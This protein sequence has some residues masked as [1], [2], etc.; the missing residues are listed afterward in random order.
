FQALD[1]LGPLAGVGVPV[2]WVERAARQQDFYAFVGIHQAGRHALGGA[3]D[4]NLDD[5]FHGVRFVLA[6]TALVPGARVG[7]F[8][9]D[10][11]GFG[12][13]AVQLIELV[14]VF[15]VDRLGIHE[16]AG[17]GPGLIGHH[18]APVDF[19]AAGLLLPLVLPG[20]HRVVL[21]RSDRV[22]DEH[23]ENDQRIGLVGIEGKLTVE[24]D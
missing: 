3:V 16:P 6:L 19:H 2:V 10:L 14:V 17:A 18:Q 15:D 4:Q 1:E 7:D 12:N 8:A 5:V 9:D 24:A 11:F 23:F 22:A 20:K 13:R 21:G